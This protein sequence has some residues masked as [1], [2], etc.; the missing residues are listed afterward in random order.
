MFYYMCNSYMAKYVWNFVHNCQKLKDFYSKFVN[1][2]LI[3]QFCAVL[4]LPS[5]KII[6]AAASNN[7]S[8]V[9]IRFWQC[10]TLPDAAPLFHTVHRSYALY[11]FPGLPPVSELFPP[12]VCKKEIRKHLP[13]FHRKQGI[14]P[15]YREVISRRSCFLH[16]SASGWQ[17][18][19][20]GR[21][22]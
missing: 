9:K 4:T 8:L 20:Q 13:W 22:P 7:S 21:L 12:A 5:A 6:T 18:R 2:A 17:N 3:C 11:A 15:P 1:F 10:C 19:S 16:C 14:L